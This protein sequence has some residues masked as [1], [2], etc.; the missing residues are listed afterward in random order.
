VIGEEGK[1]AGIPI[2]HTISF[3]AMVFILDV[4]APAGGAQVG[5]GSTIQ[6]GKSYFFP[7]GGVK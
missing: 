1:H 2:S 7:K 4:K 3:F 5:T 6:A